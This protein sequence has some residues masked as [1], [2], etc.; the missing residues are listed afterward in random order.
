MLSGCGGSSS[1]P[2]GSIALQPLAWGSS[3]LGLEQP[4]DGSNRLF[5]VE[6]GGT[7]HIVQ[8]GTVLP[9]PFLDIS[10]RVITG[11][12][13]GLLGLAFHPDFVQNRKFYVN[14]VRS[15]A[16]QIQSV[17]AE[18]TVSAANLNLADPAASAS[19]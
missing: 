15:S 18:Y 16:G 9:Q 1:P 12:E 5:V 7:I 14:Y 3:P 2:I 11:G 8:N 4:A 19:C 13:M 6:Q 10:D 17:I